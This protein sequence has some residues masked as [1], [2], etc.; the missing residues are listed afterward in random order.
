MHMSYAGSL[1]YYVII[2]SKKKFKIFEGDV[3][4]P[5][6]LQFHNFNGQLFKGK[7]PEQRLESIKPPPS[8]GLILTIYFQSLKV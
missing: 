1:T 8:Y 3:I 6:E 5:R 7:F 2:W 4:H